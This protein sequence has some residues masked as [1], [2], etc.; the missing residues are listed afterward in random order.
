MVRPGR[1]RANGFRIGIVALF[2][3][4]LDCRLAEG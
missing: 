2:R 4:L 3:V 1:T